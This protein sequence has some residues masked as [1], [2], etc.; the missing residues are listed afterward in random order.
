MDTARLA[1]IAGSLLLASA[2]F[3][4]GAAPAAP[5]AAP[6]TAAGD[7]L[8]PTATFAF[9]PSR[10]ADSTIFWDGFLN[11][12]RGF[13]HF[14]NPIGQPIYFE[15]PFNNSGIRLLFLHHEFDDDS[16]LGGGDVNVAAVQARLA[17]TERL[18]FIA[19]KDGYSWLN[20]GILPEDE[21]WN[22]IAAGLKYAVIVDREND[23][24]LT[25]GIRYQM[26][27]GEAKVLQSTTDEVSPFVSAAKGWGRFHA[28]GDVTLRVP[29]DH[30]EGND[31]LQ[32]DLHGD[33][34]IAPET[35]PGFAPVV[36]LHGLHYLSDGTKLPL[37]VGGLDYAN[38]GSADVSGSTVI[39]MGVGARYKLSPHT[40]VGADY[41][42]ALTN[43]KAD[44]MS[45]RVTVDFELTW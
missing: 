5:A 45:E 40:S 21:G 35:L 44:I 39:W 33:Y 43:W 19:T 37:S 36:E 29:F 16:Q 32:W 18:G 7:S 2:A 10:G 4:Q 22:S 30:D 26:R 8:S 3:G 34:E 17:L 6:T 1:T 12:L 14:Y 42:F 9:S 41:E 38:I 24:V 31:I 13:E 11:G 25:P 20:A 28:I 23:F 27:A 15:T